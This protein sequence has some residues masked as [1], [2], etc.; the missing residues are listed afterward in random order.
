MIPTDN[1]TMIPTDRPSRN[2][3]MIPTDSPS[4]NPTMIPSFKAR[5]QNSSASPTKIN[6]DLLYVLLP[7]LLCVSLF[8]IICVIY[9]YRIWNFEL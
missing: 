4:R 7:V 6:M 2:P 1:P 5:S 9:L 3:T 8:V